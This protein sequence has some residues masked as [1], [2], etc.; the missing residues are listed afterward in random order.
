MLS[1]LAQITKTAEHQQ[2]KYYV[3]TLL[4][5]LLIHSHVVVRLQMLNQTNLHFVKDKKKF[6]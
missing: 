4:S 3:H 6:E 5:H 1:F 2:T